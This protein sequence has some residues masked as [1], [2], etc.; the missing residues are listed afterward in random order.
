MFRLRQ[1]R[2]A[3]P[4][5]GETHLKQPGIRGVSRLTTRPLIHPAS[6]ARRLGSARGNPAGRAL[7]RYGRPSGPRAIV[8]K[9]DSIARTGWRPGTRREF[10]PELQLARNRVGGADRQV[11]QAG[12]G[13]PRARGATL[14]LRWDARTGMKSLMAHVEDGQVVQ[15]IGKIGV[16]D[17]RM[18]AA[19]AASMG[20]SAARAPSIS[21]ATA[22]EPAHRRRHVRIIMIDRLDDPGPADYLSPATEPREK[23]D[24][25]LA[26]HSIYQI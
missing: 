17:P 25:E 19:G 3:L 1:V 10:A 8:E 20:Q 13:T 15:G 26:V 11:G 18:V 22:P 5:R 4:G 24:R 12:T 23:L 2:G 6:P 16:M 7:D 14:G 9:A 21:H